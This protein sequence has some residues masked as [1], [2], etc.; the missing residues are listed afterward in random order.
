MRDMR[1]QDTVKDLGS[2][3]GSPIFYLDR[4]SSIVYSYDYNHAGN[5]IHL[6]VEEERNIRVSSQRGETSAIL[7]PQFSVSI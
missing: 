4:L 3:I 6:L 5:T 2:E 1:V 7:R